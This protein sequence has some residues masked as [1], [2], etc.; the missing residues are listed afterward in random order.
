MGSL[1]L[2][3]CN[4]TTQHISIPLIP[5]YSDPIFANCTDDIIPQPTNKNV[6]KI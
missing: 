6:N 1:R 2:Y 5:I 3:T 4:I